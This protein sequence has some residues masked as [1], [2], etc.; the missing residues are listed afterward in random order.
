MKLGIVGLPNVGKSTIFNVMTHN[1]AQTNNYMFSTLEPNIGIVDVPDERIDFLS[2]LYDADKTTYATIEFVD[3]PGLVRGSNKGEGVGNKF[4]SSIQQVDAL[5]HVVRCF[6]DDDLIHVDG[7]VNPVRDVETINLELIF[8]DIDMIER[9]IERTSKAAKSG[10]KSY[11]PILKFY[12]DLKEHLLEGKMAKS[13]KFENIEQE[14]YMNELFLITVKPVLY[15]ANVDEQGMLEDNDYT[16]ALINLA[17]SEEN[18][19]IKVCAKFEEDLASLEKDEK[20][21]FLADLGIKET[22]LERLIKKSYKLLDLMSFLTAGKK[23]V[24]AWTIKN[25]TTAPKAAGK[26]HSDF[27]RGFIRAEVFSYDDIKRLGSYNAVKEKG[28]VRSEGKTYIFKE[29]DIVLFRF[30]V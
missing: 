24:R 3:I 9:R 7:S 22:G 12:N 6:D 1:K 13:F 16:K 4:L 17:E 20:D 19:V 29:G 18:E 23:E 30:N 10:D 15:V 28:L 8:S 25:N 14:T 27:E 11:I 26:I 2:K 5:C 21:A